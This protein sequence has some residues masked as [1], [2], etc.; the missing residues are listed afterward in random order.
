[1]LA[2]IFAMG[3]HARTELRLEIAGTQNKQVE[4]ERKRNTERE[5]VRAECNSHLSKIMVAK[6]V[7]SVNG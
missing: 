6:V 5:R 7:A 1:M 2:I 4:K 3:R